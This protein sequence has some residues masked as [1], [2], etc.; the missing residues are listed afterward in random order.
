[1]DNSIIREI[2]DE[3]RK[4]TITKF[5]SK[6]KKVILTFAS[7]LFAILI[8][9]FI[10][11]YVQSNRE[12]S[13]SKIYHQAIIKEEKGQYQESV[14]LLKSIYESSSAPS[15][16]KGVASLRY[17][18]AAISDN[19]IDKA[20][21][22]YEEIAFSNKYDDYLQNLSGLLLSKLIIVNLGDNP[23]PEKA[24]V[25]EKRI[26]QVINQNQILKIETK[27][28]LAILYIKINKN[29]DARKILESIRTNQKASKL[30]KD[31]VIQLIKLIS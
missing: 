12:K 1:M 11:E 29:D 30:V 19:N 28:Q 27:E 16:V 20:L 9:Y 13:Y 26:K 7:I 22:I 2:K 10:Y 15:G 25:A 18:A 5:F 17:A 31:R 21:E 3:E 8:A 4:D 24:K 6:N 14:K 23:D